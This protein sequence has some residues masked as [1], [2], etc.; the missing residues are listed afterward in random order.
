[1]KF[2]EFLLYIIENYGAAIATAFVAWLIRKF[3]K[4]K[5]EKAAKVQAFEKLLQ[6]RPDLQAD[7]NRYLAT[8]KEKNKANAPRK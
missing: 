8:R 2:L 3:E 4:P 6:E 5:A 7:I 1:M